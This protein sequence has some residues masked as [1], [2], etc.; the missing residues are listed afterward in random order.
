M[1]DR[2]TM[3]CLGDEWRW[4]EVVCPNCCSQQP[5][6]ADT[7]LDCGA[8]LSFLR[9]H[10]RR[11]G[12]AVWLAML[13]G[14]ALLIALLTR[15]LDQMLYRG[16]PVLGW[17]DA[18]ELVGGIFLSFLGARAWVTLKDTFMQLWPSGARR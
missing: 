2:A 6:W 3:Y 9:E 17:I 15:V 12:L 10:P 13:C 4:S 14:L 11:V 16:L 18:V 8:A 1:G 5:E 7:C